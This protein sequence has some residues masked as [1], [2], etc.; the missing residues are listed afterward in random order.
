MVAIWQPI[1]L[2]E[3]KCFTNQVTSFKILGTIGIKIVSTWRVEC[4]S[5]CQMFFV[6]LFFSLSY[7]EKLQLHC[8]R[9]GTKQEWSPINPF[10]IPNS[11]YCHWA[12]TEIW[13]VSG[14]NRNVPFKSPNLCYVAVP[15][16]CDVYDFHLWRANINIE[17][18]KK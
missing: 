8:E 11:T 18:N 14:L 7:G 16:D 2:V 6:L 3:G 12:F 5:L 13:D 9:I 15:D 1:L 4:Q 17:N 10:I